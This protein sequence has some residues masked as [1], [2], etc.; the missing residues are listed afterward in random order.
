MGGGPAAQRIRRITIASSERQNLEGKALSVSS[1]AYA[2]PRERVAA[3][4]KRA[5]LVEI[6]TT[7]RSLTWR[8]AALECERFVGDPPEE[9]SREAIAR[10]ATR[11]MTGAPRRLEDIMEELMRLMLDQESEAE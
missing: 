1:P 3:R 10:E 7:V 11:A 8:H 4:S 6:L 2:S 9:N 5:I